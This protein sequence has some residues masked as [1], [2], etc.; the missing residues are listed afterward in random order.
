MLINSLIKGL[1]SLISHIHESDLWLANSSERMLGMSIL[2]QIH[3]I[4]HRLEELNVELDANI[5]SEAVN[6]DFRTFLADDY[7]PSIILFNENVDIK[8]NVNKT[9]VNTITD[10]F[11]IDN[12]KF[13]FRSTLIPPLKLALHQLMDD[14]K[15]TYN[16]LAFAL[17]SALTKMKGVLMEIKEKLDNPKDYQ[18]RKIWDDLLDYYDD[19]LSSDDYKRWKSKHSKYDFKDLRI[20]QIQEILKLSESNFFR[21]NETPT[22]GDVRNCILIKNEDLLPAGTVLTDEIK[23]SC[24]KFECFIE[25]KDKSILCVN[26]EMLGEYI[27]HHGSKFKDEEFLPVID[28]DRTMDMIHDDMAALKPNLN[29]YLKKYE[30]NRINAL[31]KDG[32]IILNSCQK[33]LK[34][35][36]RNTFL[37]EFLS[38]MLYDSDIK[39]EARELLEGRS[40]NKYL[41]QIIAA[42]D[43]FF[44]FKVGT[45]KEDF[46]KA[47]SEK[48]EKP[49]YGSVIDYFKVYQRERKGSLYQWTK[50]IVDDLKTNAYNPF[51]GILE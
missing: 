47:L 28:F 41:C 16:D 27:F 38:K 23:E 10:Y 14:E 6:I 13:Q 22:L 2:C 29:K 1:H 42:L 3:D 39:Y 19:D 43:C 34:E 8:V 24:A 49:K 40:R 18:F 37:R 51:K 25:W 15:L 17:N 31:I 26:Y 30:E 48:F 45:T 36:I 12:D 33:Y 32:T 35:D 46:A 4:I 9:F 44:V 7:W 5:N 20:K 50:K 11:P 21:Y